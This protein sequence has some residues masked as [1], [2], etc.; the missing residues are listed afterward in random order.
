MLFL[1]LAVILSGFIR[2]QEEKI[3]LQKK[4][5]WRASL[6]R[7]HTILP[8][9]LFVAFF[10]YSLPFLYSKF[11]KKKKF[12]LQKEV[13]ACVCVCC[14][15]LAPSAPQCLRHCYTLG[16]TCCLFLDDM[17]LLYYHANCLE[18]LVWRQCIINVKL[19]HHND[20]IIQNAASYSNLII[21]VKNSFAGKLH[22]CC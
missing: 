14:S 19:E 10:V 13:C 6:L 18:C 1:L 15:W 22:F 5:H 3:E 12:L 4:V 2:N 21:P 16:A 8:I 9:S 17:F 7:L 20:I 11:M